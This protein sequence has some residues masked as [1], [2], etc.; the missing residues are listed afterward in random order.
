MLEPGLVR[1]ER[2]NSGGSGVGDSS[3]SDGPGYRSY[4]VSDI[5]VDLSDDVP[6]HSFPGN[7]DHIQDVLAIAIKSREIKRR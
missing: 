5:R 4:C 2:T 1:P 7:E 3:T 6:I